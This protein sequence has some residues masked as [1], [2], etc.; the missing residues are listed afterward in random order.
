[1]L[2]LPCQQNDIK[3]RNE[4]FISIHNLYWGMTRSDS[5]KA[6]LTERGLVYKYLSEIILNFEDEKDCK[7]LSKLAGYLYF[8]RVK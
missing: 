7:A 6:I 4:L 5:R 8:N 3:N 1:M 2:F